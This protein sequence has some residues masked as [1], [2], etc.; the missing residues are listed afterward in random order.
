MGKEGKLSK[1]AKIG[2]AAIGVL[3]LVFGIVLARRLGG[4]NE[5]SKSTPAEEKGRIA[6]KAK[7][8]AAAR[9]A[10]GASVS[11]RTNKPTFVPA[12]NMSRQAP[13]RSPA[14]VDQWSVASDEAEDNGTGG[15]GPAKRSQPSLMPD[16]PQGYPAD[17]A[18][19]YGSAYPG[20]TGART[21]QAGQ[22]ESADTGSGTPAAD[23]LHGHAT[24]SPG[25][26]PHNAARVADPGARY[27]YPTSPQPADSGRSYAGTDTRY[28]S[29]SRF[30]TASAGSQLG[31]RDPRRDDGTY[32]VQPNDSYWTI[33]ERLYGTGAYFKAL[34]EHNRKKNPQQD[35]LQVG[36]VI[37]AP[38]VA[39][40]EKSYP[41]LCPK[42]SHRET[43]K[44]RAT[45]VSTRSAAA[46]RTYVVQEGDTLF[47]I[48]RNEL[49]KAARWKEIYDLNQ[50]QLGPDYH[51]LP[52]G[53][54][55]V[56]PEGDSA[57]TVTRRPGSEPPYRR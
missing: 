35:R 33:S 51:Y 43:V 39:Q 20:P 16:P 11:A 49:G 21:W 56:L 2:L 5:D 17:S 8:E 23:P 44:R 27:S 34:A 38:D 47:D 3:V 31:G 25:G 30:E 12:K 52:P 19:R 10:G 1:E 40:L 54:Q 9:E 22:A 29:G 41:D 6:V 46:G 42:P 15:S 32:E 45:M 18:V 36:D 37:S 48:A 7:D 57:D 53:V 28:G 4:S 13:K 14:D 55:L 24:Q 50:D 26:Q